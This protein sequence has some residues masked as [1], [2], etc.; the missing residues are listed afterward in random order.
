M[1]QADDEAQPR[2]PPFQ[3]QQQQQQQPRAD[4][5]TQARRRQGRPSNQHRHH[6]HNEQQQPVN[7]PILLEHI[8]D[9][10]ER[11]GRAQGVIMVS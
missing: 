2:Q 1:E 9:V 10:D 11:I 8:R 5:Q 4:T 7:F 3:Q 6:H